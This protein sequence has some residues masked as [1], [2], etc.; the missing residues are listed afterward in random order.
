VTPGYEF[1]APAFRDSSDITAFKRRRLVA[2][3]GPVAS[4]GPYPNDPFQVMSGDRRLEYM[5]GGYQLGGVGICGA[6]IIYKILLF[7]FVPSSNTV[8]IRISS[9]A[10]AFLLNGQLV[11]ISGATNSGNNG[12][13]TA[14][15]VNS[16]VFTI[17]N[18]SGVTE[19]VSGAIVTFSETTCKA[20]AL[21]GNGN[22]Y[23]F[24]YR[25]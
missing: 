12:T 13:F 22:P 9:P 2:L 11:T 24:N 18:S 15:T 23:S 25:Q 1:S 4:G 7:V 8:T 17:P 20:A 5:M 10:D 6:P 16:N 14:T 21:N 19:I 3:E